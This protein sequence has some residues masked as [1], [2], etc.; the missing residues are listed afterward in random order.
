MQQSTYQWQNYPDVMGEAI[1]I[2]NS[3]IRTNL[4]IT[5]GNS[6]TKIYLICIGY[7]VKTEGDSF[8][9]A[10]HSP[11]SAMWWCIF[12]QE[13]LLHANWPGASFPDEPSYHISCFIGV[14]L[15]MRDERRK[16]KCSIR[17]ER[18]FC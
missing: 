15:C 18:S 9:V 3:V 13:G 14:T 12:V 7:E 5:G 6:D 8:M 1:E 11:V 4:K 16:R 10:F 2:H 17:I